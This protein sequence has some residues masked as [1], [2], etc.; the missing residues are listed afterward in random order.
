MRASE[1][2]LERI[3]EAS[4]AAVMEL[5]ATGRFTY[6]NATAEQLLG[7]SRAEAF[8]REFD[9][10]AWYITRPDGSPMS[11]DELPAAR[12]LRGE[13]ARGRGA[14]DQRRPRRAPARAARQR[15]PDSPRGAR[16]C[17]GGK[18]AR[19][20]GAGT[21]A[22]TGAVAAFF[23]VTAATEAAERTVCAPAPRAR[24]GG[25]QSL[26]PRSR[27]PSS[28]TP[29]ARWARCRVR[30]WCTTRPGSARTRTPRRAWRSSRRTRCRPRCGRSSAC[31]YSTRRRAARCP[32]RKPP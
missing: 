27:P 10:P 24:A 23:D 25:G 8:R 9:A 1:A 14:R 30:S 3:L 29:P 18:P 17:E 20:T 32:S 31:S 5:D 4:P 11:P 21:G 19:E 2:R 12:A 13:R 22:V 6:L 16:G 15:R 28:R 7:V 26:P